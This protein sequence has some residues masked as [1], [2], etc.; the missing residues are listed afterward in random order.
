[1]LVDDISRVVVTE[2]MAKCLLTSYESLRGRLQT[3]IKVCGNVCGYVC[4][5]VCVC[6]VMC[7]VMCGYVWLCVFGWLCV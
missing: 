5:Y 3:V 7:V 4:G 1:M 6:V 2:D